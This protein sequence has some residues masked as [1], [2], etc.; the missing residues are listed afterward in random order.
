MKDT[1][2]EVIKYSAMDGK[3]SMTIDSMTSNPKEVMIVTLGREAYSSTRATY[4][5]ILKV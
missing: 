4:T 3:I 2:G 5:T 1:S